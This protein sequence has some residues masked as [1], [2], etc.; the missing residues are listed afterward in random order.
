MD[1]QLVDSAIKDKPTFYNY[2]VVIVKMD[3]VKPNIT[4]LETNDTRPAIAGLDYRIIGG[5]KNDFVRELLSR[6]G[7][8]VLNGRVVLPRRRSLKEQTVDWNRHKKM[9][10]R[11]N[12]MNAVLG[13][14]ERRDNIK[15]RML[16]QGSRSIRTPSKLFQLSSLA[17]RAPSVSSEVVNENGILRRAR[18]VRTKRNA[19]NYLNNIY[20]GGIGIDPLVVNNIPSLNQP[21]PA[22]AFTTANGM[23]QM[24]NILS[25]VVQ[26]PFADLMANMTRNWTKPL[27]TP[28]AGPTTSSS[29]TPTPSASTNDSSTAEQAEEQNEEDA[30]IFQRAYKSVAGAVGNICKKVTS[31]ISNRCKSYIYRET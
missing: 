18:P 21:F 26:K 17:R 2:S 4:K 25:Q 27:F 1:F 29:T 24:R 28:T 11:L 8:S 22:G 13:H 19:T 3:E 9:Q 5:E 20:K 30:G 12:A 15:R 16:R 10:K 14:A 6:A 23:N 31:Y 7:R